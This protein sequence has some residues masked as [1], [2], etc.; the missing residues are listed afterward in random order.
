MTINIKGTA[1]VLTPEIS[2]YLRK[3]LEAIEK[4][5]PK[6]GDAFIADVELGKTTNHHQ[7]GDIFRAEINVHI[8]GKAFRAVSE[9]QDLYSAIDDMKDQIGRELA[10]FKGKRLSIIRRS[11]QRLKNLL[12]KFYR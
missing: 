1:I 10:S 11:G 5:L 9:K 4:F 3:R 12:R 2:N 7:T 8:G 6:E